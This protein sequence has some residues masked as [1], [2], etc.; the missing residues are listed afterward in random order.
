MKRHYLLIFFIY[1]AILIGGLAWY[2]LFKGVNPHWTWALAIIHWMLDGAAL[3]SLL[4]FGKLHNTDITALQY[5]GAKAAARDFESMYNVTAQRAATAE[6]RNIE[7]ERKC[8]GIEVMEQQLKRATAY[9]S[10]AIEDRRREM[11]VS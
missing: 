1:H 8:K 9:L 10:H 2:L 6:R 5:Y 3:F 4:A 7:L 11:P